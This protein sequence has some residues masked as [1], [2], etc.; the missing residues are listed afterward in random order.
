MLASEPSLLNE[1][2]TGAVGAAAVVVA[3]FDDSVGWAKLPL[4]VLSAVFSQVTWIE[5]DVLQP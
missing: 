2:D 5:L 1:T 4:Q 3:E